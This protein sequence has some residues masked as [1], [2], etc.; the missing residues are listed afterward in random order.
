M[1]YVSGQLEIYKSIYEKK[2][3]ASLS[4]LLFVKYVCVLYMNILFTLRLYV[5]T[6]SMHFFPVL[7]LVT[8]NN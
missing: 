8:I 3:N 2:Q 4:V 6:A 7:Y 5:F 1:R